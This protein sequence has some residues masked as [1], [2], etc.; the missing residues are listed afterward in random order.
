M[1]AS[2]T[3]ET[4]NALTDLI[5]HAIQKHAGKSHLVEVVLDNGERFAATE[6]YSRSNN[7]IVFEVLPADS[8][9]EGA[10]ARVVPVKRIRYFDVYT[11]PS[12]FPKPYAGNWTVGFTV[13]KATA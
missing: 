9:N 10:S 12:H 6:M 5:E 7:F 2:D 3:S 11:D 1:S 8:K 13:R 4:V